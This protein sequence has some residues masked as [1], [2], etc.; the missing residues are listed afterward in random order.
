MRLYAETSISAILGPKPYFRAENQVRY[1]NDNVGYYRARAKSQPLVRPGVARPSHGP[2]YDQV[3]GRSAL[4]RPLRAETFAMNNYPTG[5]SLASHW[6]HC[7]ASEKTAFALTV[8]LTLKARTSC[9]QH[10]ESP[11]VDDVEY[12]QR[13]N[14]YICI[15]PLFLFECAH[16]YKLGV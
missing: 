1:P 3:D 14:W 9:H 4:R 15:W 8:L 2:R 13:F 6:Q 16:A 7:Q 5:N 12:T 11:G 10:R